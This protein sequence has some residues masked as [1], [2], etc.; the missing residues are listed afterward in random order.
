MIELLNERMIELLP[1]AY[2]FIQ[3]FNH[4]LIQ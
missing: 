4:S 1:G 2:L 3:A